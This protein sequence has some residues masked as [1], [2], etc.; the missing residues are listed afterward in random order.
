[1]GCA[2]GG[3]PGKVERVA[4]MMPRKKRWRDGKCLDEQ[5]K[6]IGCVNTLELA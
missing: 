6:L 4:M 1:M 2:C 3:G 5:K